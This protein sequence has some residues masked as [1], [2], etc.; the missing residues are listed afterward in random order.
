MFTSPYKLFISLIPGQS[1]SRWEIPYPIIS[2]PTY[3]DSS[4]SERS[5]AY[6]GTFSWADSSQHALLDAEL[7]QE[8]SVVDWRLI[9]PELPSNV[10]ERNLSLVITYTVEKNTGGYITYDQEVEL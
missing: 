2:N 8:L 10:Q 5:C 3:D 4:D 9:I 7:Q 1:S 6:L